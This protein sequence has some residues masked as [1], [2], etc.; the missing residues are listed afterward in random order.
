MSKC[1]ISLDVP[2]T[3]FKDWPDD[4]SESKHV[5]TFIIDNKLVVLRLNV[6]LEYLN[7]GQVGYL[8]YIFV[9]M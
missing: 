8:F 4:D 6:L 3:W 2:Q 9:V 5:A 7:T 1:A